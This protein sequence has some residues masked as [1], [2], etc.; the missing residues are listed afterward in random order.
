MLAELVVDC[1]INLQPKPNIEFKK[2]AAS[3]VPKKMSKGET[4]FF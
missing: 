3:K 4:L 2:A 1:T